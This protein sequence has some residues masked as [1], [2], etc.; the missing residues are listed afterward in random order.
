MDNDTEVLC[1]NKAA[2]LWKHQES[3]RTVRS[4][5]LMIFR[6]GNTHDTQNDYKNTTDY[7]QHPSSSNQSK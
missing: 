4:A 3:A 5:N 2:N 1:K 6:T 7:K